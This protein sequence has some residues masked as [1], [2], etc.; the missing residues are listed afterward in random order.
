MGAKTESLDPP[1][2]FVPWIVVDGEHDNEIQ[3]AAMDN[4]LALVC[5]LYKVDLVKSLSA[6]NNFVECSREQNQ[7]SV[8]SLNF[9]LLETD[10]IVSNCPTWRLNKF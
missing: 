4:L 2:N 9:F 10:P 1:H 8:R 3:Q 6:G 5:K 7:P